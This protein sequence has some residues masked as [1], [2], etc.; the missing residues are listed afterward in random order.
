MD[1]MER[2]L[3]ASLKNG[4]F[5]HLTPERSRIMAAIRGK[6]NKSTERRLQMAL[7]RNAIGGFVLHPMGVAGKP[8]FY[9]MKKHLA[10][11]VDGCFWH[12]CRRCG[13]I[14]K[15]NSSFWAQKIQRN[16]QRDRRIQHVLAAKGIQVLRFWEH[17]LAEEL[18]A[19]V[20]RVRLGLARRPRK[21]LGK[22]PLPGIL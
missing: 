15:S 7:V 21:L 1:E 10:V 6:G 4:R 3:K 5:E 12:G 11:F 2:L 8:D 22:R 17:Q 14:P 9:F 13:H 20:S 18:D 19:C 16:R